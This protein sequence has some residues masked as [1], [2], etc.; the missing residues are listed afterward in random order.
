MVNRII[1]RDI[2]GKVLPGGTQLDSEDAAAMAAAR[3]AKPKTQS[4]DALLKQAGFDDS[5]TAPEHLRL[6]ARLGS[7]GRAGSVQ[8]LRAFLQLT[9]K[10]EAVTG[11]MQMLPDGRCPVCGCTPANEIQIGVNALAELVQAIREAKAQKE[12]EMATGNSQS[13]AHVNAS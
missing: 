3:W 1:Q 12:A 9:G 10:T 5:S 6:L 11:D 8:A 13:S 2:D 4:T 7:S